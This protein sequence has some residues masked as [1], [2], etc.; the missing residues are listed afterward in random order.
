M[1][2]PDF[3]SLHPATLAIC[4]VL[5]TLGSS[6]VLSIP[7]VLL[8]RYLF[9]QIV[10]GG[11]GKGEVQA[12]RE[13]LPPPES[14]PPANTPIQR[15]RGMSGRASTVL[16]SQ[17]NMTALI[18][19]VTSLQ[20]GH[21]PH[22]GEAVFKSKTEYD[23]A[24]V[25]LKIY[26]GYILGVQ[27]I[28]VLSLGL[29]ARSNAQVATILAAQGVNPWLWAAF[30][31]SSCFYNVGCGSLHFFITGNVME[32]TCTTCHQGITCIGL[33]LAV[34]D[35]ELRAGDFLYV[36]RGWKLPVPHS[37]AIHCAGLELERTPWSLVTTNAQSDSLSDAQSPPCIDSLVPKPRDLDASCGT[38]LYIPLNFSFDGD[39]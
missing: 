23:A 15:L 13:K 36:A 18:G 25:L 39:L 1:V 28:G 8:R 22:A 7:P 24:G 17:V 34:F 19:S 37:L 9:R 5:M 4:Y 11:E 12:A 14:Q 6:I 21:S 33:S 26:V 27:G 32:L 31:T 35:G 16:F 10:R 38:L 29:Y 2:P 30:H 3:T 20:A